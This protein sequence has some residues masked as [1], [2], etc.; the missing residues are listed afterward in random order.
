MDLELTTEELGIIETSSLESVLSYI[1]E[2]QDKCEDMDI[3][4]LQDN[5]SEIEDHVE[6]LLL[7]IN[8]AKKLNRRPNVSEP[9]EESPVAEPQSDSVE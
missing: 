4:S 6:A 1:A 8:L 9:T 2:L 5:L 3:Y 7:R